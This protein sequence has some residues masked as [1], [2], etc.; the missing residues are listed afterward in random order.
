M[1]IPVGDKSR[2]CDLKRTI[3]L[4][5][6]AIYLILQNDP[7]KCGVRDEVIDRLKS[8]NDS[9]LKNIQASCG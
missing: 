8:T 4:S 7:Q 2:Q 1:S 9:L 6:Q 5:G 3:L